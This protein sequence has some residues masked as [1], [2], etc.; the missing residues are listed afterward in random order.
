M[1]K[2][3]S[4]MRSCEERKCHVGGNTNSKT[5]GGTSL[6]Y[7]QVV[8]PDLLKVLIRRVLQSSPQPPLRS[9]IW[10]Y[11]GPG[12]AQ[13]P[14]PPPDASTHLA[15]QPSCQLVS[16]INLLLGASSVQLLD[17][18]PHCLR[19]QGVGRGEGARQ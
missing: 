7:N 12:P 9:L 17:E 16:S 18:L 13:P 8:F 19:F 4:V 1:E 14:D 5:M 3:D 15:L 11:P 6:L 2:L 10:Y